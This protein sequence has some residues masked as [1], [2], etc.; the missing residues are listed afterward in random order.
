MRLT[1]LLTAFAA[2]ALVAVAC[3][4]DDPEPTPAPAQ[5][6]QTQPAPASQPE[7]GA[8]QWDSPP[9]M[10]ID[11]SKGYGAVFELEKGESF[12]V[13]LYAD[14]VP[15][16]VNNFVFLAR[17]GFY[18]GV[19]FHRVLEGFMAQTGDPTGTGTG[20]PGYRFE[21]EFHPDLSH[22]S[23]GI[24]SMANAGG[25]ATNGSQFFITF[26]ETAFLDYLNPDG[27][28]KDCAQRGVSC[29]SVFG[30]VTGDGMDVVNNITLRNPSEATAPGDVISTIRIVEGARPAAAAA[31]Q[32]TPEPTPEPQGGPPW[33]SPPDMVIDTSKGYGA[34][35]ELEKGESFEVELYAD[36]VPGVVNNFVFLAREGFYD[37]VTFHR[38]LEGFMAQ[39][40]DPTGTGT[41]GPGYRFESEFHP[42]LS[43]DSAGILSM[44]NAGGLATNGSQF[45]ITFR[46]TA[47]LDYLNPDGSEKDCAQRGVSCH[48]VFG[49]VTGDG[50]DVVNNIALRNPSEATAPGD[51]IS[52]IRIIE[53]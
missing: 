42:D 43:H 51:V 47:F 11:T 28:E 38:V 18:D 41:G 14:K 44:A 50:M 10:V 26:R 3:G 29:H 4:S 19:T 6:S 9:D 30:K 52:T 32:P 39:T 48:S 49:K 46:E 17:E 13:E 40:G 53:E 24:L 5:Q 1:I 36:K 7:S 35:F 21:S 23:A 37:G 16:V 25:L 15:G 8:K 45:F 27:S 2:L 12:E 31:P 34:V 20:G 33:D 22:D